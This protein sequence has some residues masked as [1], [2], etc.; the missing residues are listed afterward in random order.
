MPM[1]VSLAALPQSD[2]EGKLAHD[3]DDVASILEAALRPIA[4]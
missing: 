1:M 2:V 4:A 3:M